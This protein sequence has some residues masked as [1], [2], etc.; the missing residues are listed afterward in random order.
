MHQWHCKGEIID[1]KTIPDEFIEDTWASMAK[2]PH[3]TFLILTKRPR[4]MLEAVS[5]FIPKYGILPNV[6][7]GCT[8]VNQQEADEKIPIFLQ[9]PGKKFLSIEP[10]LTEINLPLN[11]EFPD[12]D[13]CYEDMR[14]RIN[15]VILGCETGTGARPMDNE[16]A[17]SIVQKCKSAGVPVFVKQIS[18]NGKPSKNIDEWPEELRVRELP[19]GR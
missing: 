19:W 18:I 13:G 1:I 4:R 16:W 17:I 9:V 5:F 14:H 3:N 2:N 10:I 8:V 12:S 15:A 7:L 11:D 6:W